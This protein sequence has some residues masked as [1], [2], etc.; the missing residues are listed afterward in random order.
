MMR[1][2][3]ITLSPAFNFRY[4]GLALIAGLFATAVIVLQLSLNQT[5]ALVFSLIVITLWASDKMAGLTAGLIFFLTK[6]FW[7]RLAYSVDISSGANSGFDLLGVAPALILAAI[8]LWQVSLDLVLGRILFPDRSRRLMLAFAAVGFL[9]IFTSG[10]PVIGLGGFER[11]ILPNMMI[12]FLTASIISDVSQLK[13]IMKAMIIVGLISSVYAIGQ[14]IVGLYPWELEWFLNEASENG[15]AGWLTIGLRGIE[16]RIFSLFYGYMDFFF[17]NILI[18]S[19]ALAFRADWTGKWRLVYRLYVLSWLG[20]LFL[21]LER[22]PIVMILIVLF[23][24]RFIEST[25]TGRKRIIWAAVLIAAAFY[26]LLLVGG[27]LLNATGADKLMRLAELASPLEAVSI[28]DRAETKWLP[29]LETIK[30]NPLGVGIGYGSQ[31]RASENASQSENFVKPHNEIIQKALETGLIGA[32]IFSL[33][34]ISI[35]RDTIILVRAKVSRRYGIAMAAAAI[36]FGVCGMVNLPF[37]G[38]SGLFF[39]LLA[40]AMLGLKDG[41]LHTETASQTDV[42]CADTT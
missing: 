36:A 26:F 21:S 23:V 34:L 12:L 41:M 8:I 37:S 14:Y 18:F 1:R 39:W 32:L 5:L 20:V 3:V 42:Q 31:T 16:F 29:A 11:N 25:S 9:S 40:G 30:N 6:S 4:F 10:S 19:L 13:I 2:A 24:A 15:L 22:M 35:F 38:S 27:P 33:L 7:V 17:T 28:Q